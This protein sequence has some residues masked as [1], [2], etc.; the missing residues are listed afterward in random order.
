MFTISWSSVSLLTSAAVSDALKA[1][2]T[3]LCCTEFV[4]KNDVLQLD[5]AQLSP[6]QCW[7]KQ[8]SWWK[9]CFAFCRSQKAAC[10]LL[11][12][13]YQA[14][15]PPHQ[16][17][18]LMKFRKFRSLLSFANLR[19]YSTYLKTNKK[20]FDLKFTEFNFYASSSKEVRISLN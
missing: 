11:I 2:P 3:Q 13:L 9:P 6:L 14:S 17:N 1:A 15:L 4:K 16:F 20:H 5:S 7:V 18:F 10:L 12:F 19:T 8:R